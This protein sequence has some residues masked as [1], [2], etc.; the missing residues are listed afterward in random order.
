MALRRKDNY[1]AH[2]FI[3][4]IPEGRSLSMG[5]LFRLSHPIYHILHIH[6]ILQDWELSNQTYQPRRVGNGPVIA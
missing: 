4:G 3:G 5:N 2:R 1:Q 6:D